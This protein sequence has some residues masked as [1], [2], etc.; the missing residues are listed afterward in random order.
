MCRKHLSTDA[1]GRNSW[2]WMIIIQAAA[3]LCVVYFIAAVIILP[4]WELKT[5]HLVQVE[6]VVQTV[7]DELPTVSLVTE[8]CNDPYR[9]R[10]SE[11]L[12][13]GI[14]EKVSNLEMR[15][16]W[17]KPEESP[18][19]MNLLALS[20]GIK[21]K[22]LV[23]EMVNKFLGSNFTVMLFHYDRNVD[24]WKEFG[25]NDKVIHVAAAKQ[26]KWWF[27][28]RFLHPDIVDDYDYI[29]LWD[30]DLGVENFN[31]KRYLSIVKD[32]GLHI[33][34]PGLDPKKSEIHHQIT[35]RGRRGIVHRRIYRKNACYKNS[36]APPCTGWIE[37][38]APVFSRSAWRCVWH[39]IQNDLIH[40]WGLDLHLG[41]CAQGDRTRNVGV[42]DAEYV[43]HHGL[44]TLGEPRAKKAI[45]KA[46]VIDKRVEVRR[47]SFNEY[48]IFIRRWEEAVTKDV[49]WE[50]PYTEPIRSLI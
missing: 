11:S 46:N 40:A 2:L 20:A 23:N 48:K 32:E 24:D 26:T 3:F 19:S 42:V 38:M 8:S 13:E 34:Q 22:R 7:G 39:M 41:Y 12:P 10:G 16:L 6:T 33:S 28:K 29:F 14:V 31:P 21:Q 9:P 30:E 18:S 45:P 5:S 43:V 50:D 35:A 37:V 27:A 4:V 47:Q 15:P 44:P 1:K 25:W 17:G 49:C 36:T